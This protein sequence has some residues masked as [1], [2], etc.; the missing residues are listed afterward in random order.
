MN[1][2]E[3]ISR[4]QSMMGVISEKL[5]DIQGTPLYHKTSTS[6]GIDIINL[7]SLRGTLPSDYYLTLDKRLANTRTQRA[8]SFTRDKGWVPNQTIGVGLDSP[9]ED[10]NITFVLD[11]DKLKTKYRVEPFNYD[12]IDPTHEYKDK[13][14]ELEERVL[15]DEIYPLRKYV[16]DIIYTGDNPEV[17]EI[18]DGYLNR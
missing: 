4:I 15:T 8:I 10:S 17:Q 14:K 2:Q 13:S 6:R 12:A 1:L 18:I 3:Q 16:I 5:E 9:I 7:D 11:K